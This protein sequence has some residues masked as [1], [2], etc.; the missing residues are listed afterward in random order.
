[1]EKSLYSSYCKIAEPLLS[2]FSAVRPFLDRALTISAS[3]SCGIE[4][5]TQS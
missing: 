4:T 5:I 1:M 3:E 2:I